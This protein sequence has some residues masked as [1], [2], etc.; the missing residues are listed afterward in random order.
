MEKMK[1]AVSRQRVRKQS[2]LCI[3]RIGQ[4]CFGAFPE[5]F[6]TAGLFADIDVAAAE[7]IELGPEAVDARLQFRRRPV[8]QS[9]QFER[10]LGAENRSADRSFSREARR[11][12]D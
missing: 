7:V 11:Y 1:N 4:V 12:S 2:R 3:E 8:H 9:R 5:Q 10:P 6:E